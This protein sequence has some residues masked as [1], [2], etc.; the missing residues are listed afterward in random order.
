MTYGEAI[1]YVMDVLKRFDALPPDAQIPR[2]D[3]VFTF[4]NN[5]TGL[6]HLTFGELVQRAM[7]RQD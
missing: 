1:E 3:V 5:G 6:T 4:G 7:S 2:N